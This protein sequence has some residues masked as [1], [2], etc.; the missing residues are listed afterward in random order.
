MPNHKS[1]ICV[2]RKEI[3][4]VDGTHEIGVLHLAEVFYYSVFHTMV[5]VIV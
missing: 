3:W 5:K 2:A 4:A 1:G